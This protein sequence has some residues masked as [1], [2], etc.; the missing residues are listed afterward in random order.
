MTQESGMPSSSRAKREG[1]GVVATWVGLAAI[2]Y[3]ITSRIRLYAK[4]TAGRMSQAFPRSLDGTSPVPLAG[5][6]G[7]ATLNLLEPALADRGALGSWTLCAVAI[8]RQV[9]R[10]SKR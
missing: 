9:K 1:K 4:A 6:A 5:P 2:A 7:R 3:R 8:S 10:G